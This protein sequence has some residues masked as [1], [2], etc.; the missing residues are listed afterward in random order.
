MSVACPHCGSTE[1]QRRAGSLGSVRI[2]DACGRQFSSPTPLWERLFFA[3]LF[4]VPGLVFGLIA[5][6]LFFGMLTNNLQAGGGGFGCLGVLSVF[7]ALCLVQGFRELAGR[8]RRPRD[9]LDLDSPREVEEARS[10]ESTSRLAPRIPQDQAESLVLEIAAKYGAKKILRKLGSIPEDH[11]DNAAAHFAL[12]MR[13]DETPLILLDTS[14]LQNGKAG[15]LL[16]NRGLYS[17][18]RS[19]PFWLADINDVSCS[20]PGFERYVFLYL[21]TA[22]ILVFAYLGGMM[23][24]G[25][26]LLLSHLGLLPRPFALG[27]SI[28]SIALSLYLV[29]FVFVGFRQLQTQ[30]LVNGKAVYRGRHRLRRAFWIELLTALAEAARQVQAGKDGG[31][32]KPS[33]VVLET[34][35][36]SRE[37]ESV[38]CDTFAIPHG[39]ISSR[40]S[41]TWIKR[42][43]PRCVS[44]RVKW[45]KLPHWTFS[46]ATALTLC[47][48]WATAGSIT[49]PTAVR[50]RSKCVS[51]G[52]VIVVPP[53]MS[54]P[55]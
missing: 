37:G 41:V 53:T 51:A 39:K 20:T 3:A 49:T 23:G 43:I 35:V 17:S 27:W 4:I 14:F 31:R 54:A 40:T 21:L 11:V 22:G 47:A 33:L 6:F 9:E 36:Q 8:A 2:C 24:G 52:R 16:T 25:L 5:A 34:T 32:R 38:E 42:A 7:A 48:S 28:L 44:G 13:E 45:S 26:G 55:T 15:L 18:F 19:R 12:D 1:S 46:A 29:V 30:L 10:R 50:K